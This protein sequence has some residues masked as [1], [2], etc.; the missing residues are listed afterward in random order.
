[1][2]AAAELIATVPPT[3]TFSGWTDLLNVTPPW[4]GNSDVFLGLQ[5]A[6]NDISAAK[7][8]SLI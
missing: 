2:R 1:M 4:L 3:S 8:A 7:Y 6:L 5:R